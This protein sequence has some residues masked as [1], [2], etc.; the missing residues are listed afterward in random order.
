MNDGPPARIRINH[1][2]YHASHIGTTCDGRQFFLTQAFVPGVCEYLAVYVF[3]ANGALLEARID[4]LGPREQVDEA[5]ARALFAA[6]LAD[7]GDVTLGP[8]EVAPFQLER[9]GTVFGLVAHPPEEEDEDWCV[10]LEPGDFMCF[11]PP[12]DGDYDT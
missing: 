6:R 4:D 7:L 5:A 12:W 3:D 11:Y 10:T 8:I 9:F 2:D 1:D